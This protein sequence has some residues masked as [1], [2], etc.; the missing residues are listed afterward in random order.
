MS[1]LVKWSVVS[2]SEHFCGSG[3][4]EVGATDHLPLTTDRLLSSFLLDVDH[5]GSREHLRVDHVDQ[6][7]TL[8]GHH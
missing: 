6:L 7:L 8:A 2:G 4:L 1:A 3:N 5:D